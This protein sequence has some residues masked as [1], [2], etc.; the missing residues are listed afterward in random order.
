MK[1]VAR[2]TIFVLALL[3]L[4]ST[5]R[6][7]DVAMNAAGMENLTVASCVATPN[8]SSDSS[9][10]GGE[11]YIT[12]VCSGT[13]DQGYGFHFDYP[14][15]APLSGT[16]FGVN[17]AYAGS[18]TNTGNIVHTA[19]ICCAVGIGALLTPLTCGTAVTS[20]ANANPGNTLS[21]ALGLSQNISIGQPGLP[22]GITPN[23]SCFLK[24]VRPASTNV[25]DTYLT[26]TREISVRMHY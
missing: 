25:S 26:P 17:I 3:A 14:A 11:T 8:N 5:V 23:V 21:N 6:A 4:A 22:A 10:V 20:A 16:P 12:R 24:I 2:C 9:G 13:V 18:D 7:G 19:Q 1:H 15:D